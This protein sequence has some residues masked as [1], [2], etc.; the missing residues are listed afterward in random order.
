MI[1]YRLRGGRLDVIAVPGYELGFPAGKSAGDEFLEKVAD[2]VSSNPD[3]GVS[4][5]DP[6]AVT[7]GR[8]K[9]QVGEGA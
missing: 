5:D 3:G 8:G 2:G 7:V 4:E 1:P 9:V 6:G